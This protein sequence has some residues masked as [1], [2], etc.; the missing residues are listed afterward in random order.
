MSE[1]DK[2]E[3][4]EVFHDEFIIINNN[5]KLLTLK[6]SYLFKKITHNINRSRLTKTNLTTFLSDF[7][8]KKI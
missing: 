1:L 4:L 3:E 2:V 6:I 8:I 5:F 7:N